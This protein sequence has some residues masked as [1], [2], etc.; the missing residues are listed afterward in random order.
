MYDAAITSVEY[1]LITFG[2]RRFACQ[3]AAC[4]V[5]IEGDQAQLR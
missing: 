1:R 5:N 4:G 3:Y 2:D